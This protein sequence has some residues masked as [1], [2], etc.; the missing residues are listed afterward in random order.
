MVNLQK[1]FLARRFNENFAMEN[2]GKNFHAHVKE[3]VDAGN[4][5]YKAEQTAAK[6]ARMSAE[7][8]RKQE[9]MDQRNAERQALAA[10]R[11]ERRQ[12]KIIFGLNFSPN[13]PYSTLIRPLKVQD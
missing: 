10:K 4:A 5:K 13:S 3:A 9:I 8:A 2:Q 6:E 12:V 7:R 11:E 1:Y